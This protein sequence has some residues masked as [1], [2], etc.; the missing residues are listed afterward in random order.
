LLLISSYNNMFISKFE[1]FTLFFGCNFFL[2]FFYNYV[3]TFSTTK[4]VLG[5]VLVKFYGG[6]LFKGIFSNFWVSLIISPNSFL[7]FHHKKLHRNLSF[8]LGGEWNQGKLKQSDENCN[9]FS[10]SAT[11]G[12]CY[13]AFYHSTILPFNGNTTIL[14]YKVIWS[15]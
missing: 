7:R 8:Y 11:R 4:G 1:W 9:I 15:W 14:C 6:I 3:P 12:Q 2:T 13:E 10:F 5:W